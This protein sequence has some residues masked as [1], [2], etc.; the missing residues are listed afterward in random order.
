MPIGP[1]EHRPW[2]IVEM[3]VRRKPI[4]K[5]QQKRYAPHRRAGNCEILPDDV[6]RAVFRQVTRPFSKRPLKH[7]KTT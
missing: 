1:F 2:G 4:P 7:A 3:G 6:E 5:R